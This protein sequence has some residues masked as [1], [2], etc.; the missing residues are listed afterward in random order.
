[1]TDTIPTGRALP[2]SPFV[3]GLIWMGL[4]MVAFI[5]M[6]V[7]SREMAGTLSIRQVLF[8]RALVGL[9]V[10]LAVGRAVFPEIR[11]M[12]AVPLHLARNVVHFTAQYF[13]TIGIVLLPL[14]SVFALEFTMPIWVTLFAWL[15]LREKIS[16]QRILA[17]AGGFVGVLIIVRPGIGMIDP[18]AGLVLIAA[19]GYGLSLIMVKRLTGHCSPGAIVVWMIL[20]QLPLGLIAALTDWRPVP[21]AAVPWMVVAGIGA[22]AAHFCQAQ[23]LRRLEASVVIP[24]DFLRVPMAAVVGFYAYGEAIDLWV[25]L[26][27]GIIILSNLQAVLAERRGR[28]TGAAEVEPLVRPDPPR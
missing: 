8:F 10:I 17:T 11:R 19:A 12:R 7:G 1:M 2:G 23:A 20:I 24:I 4:S 25:F 18:A 16:R 13:W 5:A 14:A 27:G 3:Q 22:L 15:L 9:F 26:G 21:M 6:S 28:I